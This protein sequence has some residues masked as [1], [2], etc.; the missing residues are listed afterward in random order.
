MVKSKLE[1]MDAE[2]MDGLMTE[3]IEGI[4]MPVVKMMLAQ[5]TDEERKEVFKDYTKDGKR[6]SQK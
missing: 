1:E 6:K 3:M 4:K 5:L 2:V